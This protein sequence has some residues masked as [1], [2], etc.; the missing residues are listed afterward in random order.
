MYGNFFQALYSLLLKALNIVL[1][2]LNMDLTLISR[3]HF[4]SLKIPLLIPG[5]FVVGYFVN[6]LV[7][8]GYIW[9]EIIF[10]KGLVKLSEIGY[11]DDLMKV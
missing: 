11:L 2:P 8:W 4:R 7:I 5:N 6:F 10:L 9:E 1:W 3:L